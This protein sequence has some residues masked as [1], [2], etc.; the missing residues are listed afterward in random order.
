MTEEWLDVNRANWDDRARVHAVSEFYD[1][2]GFRA[3]S[4]SLRPFE[5]AE[6]GDVTG[7]TLLHLQCHMGDDTLSWARRGARVTGLDFSPTAVE[8]ARELAA[9]TGLADR[10][11]FV[12]SDVY[13]A[14]EALSG[15]RFDVVYTGIGALVWLPDLT[16]WARVVADLLVDG[17]FLYLAEFHPLAELLG[18]DGRT[19]RHDYFHTDAQTWDEPHTY[20]D[21]PQLTSTRSVQWQHPLGEVVTALA[22]AGLHLDFLREHEH[23]LFRRYPVLESTGTGEYRFPPGHPRLPQMYSLRA[24]KPG[25]PG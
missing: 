11:R 5:V 21:G 1:L 6:V 17:G 23:T 25:G 22:A 9:D 16:R 15:E 19:L 24:T 8:T 13:S 20:T 7:R 18:E 12:V 14:R 10:A 2:A 3:G 4:S